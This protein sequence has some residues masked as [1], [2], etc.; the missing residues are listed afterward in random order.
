M[1]WLV[2]VSKSGGQSN[3]HINRVGSIC[4]IRGVADAA[5]VNFDIDN[6]RYTEYLVG[7][8]PLKDVKNTC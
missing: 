8:S 1:L 7:N 4:I 3:G 5:I 6:R 2:V